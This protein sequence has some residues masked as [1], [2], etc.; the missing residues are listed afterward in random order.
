[1][2][3]TLTHNWGWVVLR[4]VVALLFGAL[5]LFYP[6]V[7]LAVLIVWFGVYAFVDGM[8]L[9]ISA[10]ANRRGEPRWGVLVLGG[11]LG[12]AAGLVAFFMPA[13]TALT[14]LL[15]IAAWSVVIGVDEIIAAIRVRK[16]IRGEWLLVVAGLLAVAFGVILFVEPGVGALALLLWIGAYAVVRGI[17]LIAL[18]FRLR[19]WERLH[20]AGGAMPRPA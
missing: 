2:I 11:L 7:T 16:E 5:A 1:M 13:L 15:I 8:F 10:I 12:V 4:G 17:L 18:G 6:A 3:E 14:L 20:G 9:V 19:N